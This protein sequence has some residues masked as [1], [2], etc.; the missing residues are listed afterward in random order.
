MH[1]I[2]TLSSTEMS[3]TGKFGKNEPKMPFYLKNPPYLKNPENMDLKSPKNP[4]VF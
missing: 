2:K 4:R 1:Y 3:R